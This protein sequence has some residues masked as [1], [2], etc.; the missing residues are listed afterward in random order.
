VTQLHRAKARHFHALHRDGSVL[1]LANAW[2]VAGARQVEQDGGTAVAT[3]SAGWHLSGDSDRSART[4]A[5]DLV[6]AVVAA[7]DVPVSADV[8]DGFAG[9][10]EGVADTVRC[11]IAAGA[12]GIDIGD[13]GYAMA[14]PLRP[15]ADQAERIAA[16]RAA[17]DDVD[18]PLFVNA[19]IDVF[20][21]T[22]EPNTELLSATLA[23][24]A[25]YLAAGADGI[26]VPGVI[27]AATIT[28]LVAGVPAPLSV[29]AGPDAL[30]FA[31]LGGLGVRRISALRAG[32]VTGPVQHC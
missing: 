1:V 30:G 8:E 5:L 29:L 11:V 26:F 18:V 20:L 24:V 13:S 10:P 14:A 23:R 19:R 21:R 27:D 4:R 7:V 3:S 12:V 2:D 15:M 9:D 25:A 6:A 32:K 31:T 28:A 17:A 16:A 22:R